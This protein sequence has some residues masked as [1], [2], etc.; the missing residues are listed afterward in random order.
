L[1]GP[2]IAGVFGF[3]LGFLPGVPHARTYFYLQ[4]FFIVLSASGILIIGTVLSISI[5]DK[6]KKN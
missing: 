3:K 6:F 1:F 2:I 5:K 4:P